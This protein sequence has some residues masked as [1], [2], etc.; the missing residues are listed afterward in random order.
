MDITLLLLLASGALLLPLIGGGEDGDDE[1]EIRG[2]LGDDEDL[3]GTE[4]NDRILGFDG[5]DIINAGG[6]LDFVNAGLGNDTVNGGDGRDEIEG[7]AGDDT[8]N[9]DEGG[10]IIRGGAGNDT[11]NGGYGNDKVEGGEGN[12]VIFGGPAARAIGPDGELVNAAD[13]TDTLRG[14]GGEDT[15]YIWGGDG[16]AFGGINR[17]DPG[18]PS[19]DEKDELILV[20]GEARLEDGQGT[21]D[22][23]ALANIEDAEETFATIVE[24]DESEHRMILTVDIDLDGSAVTPQVGFEATESTID[25]DGDTVNGFLITAKLL[26]PEDFPGVEFEESSAFFRGEANPTSDDLQT[27]VENNYDI[28]VVYTDAATNDYFTPQDTVAAIKDVIPANP[29]IPGT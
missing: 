28:E 16:Q 17:D 5:N 26:N 12:D 25:E 20:T 23:Y 2:T 21:T 11:I 14:Q 27:F 15:I 1:D 10:D 3:R 29:A 4:G 13:R 8:L 24:F 9:G 6:G 22:F 19:V 7:R 18:I